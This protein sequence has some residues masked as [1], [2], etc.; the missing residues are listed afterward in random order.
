M[1]PP[2][3]S[4]TLSDFAR[5]MITDFSVQEILDHL[6][7]R[8]TE[9][10]PLTAVGVTMISADRQPRYV[11][12][13]N[14]DALR[15]EQLQSEM[16]E[17][18]C[19]LAYETGEACLVED[20][21]HD[22]R[23]PRFGPP[24]LEAGLRAAF[25]IPLLHQGAW[26]GALDLYRT[27]PGTLT[28][29]ELAEAQILATVVSAYL[30]NAEHRAE[31]RELNEQMREAANRD[32]LTGLPNR[33]LLMA[34]LEQ[35]LT[36]TRDTGRP[37]GLLFVDLDG[38]KA[39]NDDHGHD[40]G[41]ELLIEVAHRLQQVV[42]PADTLAR[43]AG[44]EF[45]MLCAE[46]EAPHHADAVVARIQRQ[47]ETPF[48]FAHATVQIRV[49]VGV[50][51]SGPLSDSPALLLRNADRDL[52]RKKR[53]RRRGRRHILSD[54]QQ[55]SQP[56][57]LEVAL[58][59]AI[60]QD[61]LRLVYQPIVTAED[62]VLA[63]MEA[64]L[65]WRHPT[66]GDVPP[67]AL[68]SFSEHNGMIAPLGAW[69]LNHA[70]AQHHRWRELV[71]P[72]LVMNVN[73]SAHQFMARGFVHS[74]T[75]ALAVHDTPPSALMLEVTET[76][77]VRDVDR[78]RKVLADLRGLGIGLSLDDFGS[79]YSSL[80]YLLSFVVDHI[81]IDHDFVRDIGQDPTSLKI[82]SAMISLAHDLG[83]KVL[84]EGVESQAQLDVLAGLG[85]DFCQ[86][87]YFGRPMSTEAFEAL[88]LGSGT[89]AAPLLP[90]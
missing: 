22:D 56:A 45:V 24:A 11:A 63:G 21:E 48:E 90:Y 58:R 2:S 50:A 16:R 27:T 67:A 76:A 51:F 29:E 87:Y 5:A 8:M 55:L 10:L 1:T 78:A 82:V 53:E 59:Q 79:G 7:E 15:F 86:G 19:L 20:L 39:V 84:A 88:L 81:K 49:S 3:L 6:V 52:Y 83:V 54:A 30:V 65:R 26:L 61:E 75:S 60:A 23:F 17:G 34:Q 72:E 12:A 37:V 4:V 33:S 68:I 64:L 47:F 32:P 42:R 62:G 74:V 43:L 13:S 40:S 69:V 9:V 77:L 31:L 41:D 18:P 57:D 38:F 71:D 36:R 85:C 44:D 25:A 28:P 70:C 46:L 66:L 89:R 14:P 35:A 73:V 80:K